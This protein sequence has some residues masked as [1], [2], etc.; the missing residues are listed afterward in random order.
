MSTCS[1][2]AL[3]SVLPVT[4]GIDLRPDFA[5]RASTSDST[6]VLP[7]AGRVSAA[8]PC[9][10]RR[11]RCGVAW[12]CLLRS[13]AADVG[14]VGHDDALN[15]AQHWLP[16]HRLAQP[17]EHEPRRL[18]GDAD[19]SARP[20]GPRCRSWRTHISTIT[21]SQS[22]AAP[23][24]RGR[25]S[26]SGRENCLRHLAHFHTRRSVSA[27]PP[28]ASGAPSVLMLGREEV[29]LVAPQWGHRRPP[30]CFAD[31]ALLRAS[32]VL[33]CSRT[34]RPRRRQPASS[35]QPV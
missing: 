28:W 9:A 33:P 24:C 15:R 27:C 20:R 29:R 30:R 34:P 35:V 5:G 14:L 3:R 12:R 13:R 8:C 22:E 19:A 17:V 4:S 2:M 6:D 16:L 10:M 23:W 11:L 21:V 7:M 32:A 31:V 25:S 1:A 26:L 18:G